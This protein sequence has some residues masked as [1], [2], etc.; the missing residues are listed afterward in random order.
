MQD[1][2]N[3]EVRETLSPNELNRQL[4]DLLSHLPTGKGRFFPFEHAAQHLTNPDDLVPKDLGETTDVFQTFEKDQALV[5]EDVPRRGNSG[6]K[7]RILEKFDDLMESTKVTKAQIRSLRMSLEHMCDFG[8]EPDKGEV[9]GFNLPV[10][11]YGFN[12]L[13]NDFQ[14]NPDSGGIF[15]DD[16][17]MGIELLCYGQANRQDGLMRAYI[18]QAKGIGEAMAK[19]LGRPP[20]EENESDMETLKVVLDFWGIPTWGAKVPSE[21]IKINEQILD[22]WALQIEQYYGVTPTEERTIPKQG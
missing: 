5:D 2:E 16:I 12:H 3:S 14:K 22:G 7:V 9:N 19:G 20:K 11:L 13:A 15:D 4:F 17:A 10:T 21:L 1:L 18:D 6:Y 8:V